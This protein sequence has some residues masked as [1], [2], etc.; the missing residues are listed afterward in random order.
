LRI[1][2]ATC[3]EDIRHGGCF[4]SLSCAPSLRPSRFFILRLQPLL[5]M[6]AP[7]FLHRRQRK[8][9]PLPLSDAAMQKG[10]HSLIFCSSPQ[11]QPA[12][13]IIQLQS[14]FPVFSLLCL[15]P[16]LLDVFLSLGG[17]HGTFPFLLSRWI[18]AESVLVHGRIWNTIYNMLLYIIIK[19]MHTYQLIKLNG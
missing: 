10:I 4:S 16:R 19:H 3:D 15:R 12:Y 6:D 9:A 1:G 7:K 13:P 18:G 5:V 14:N 2:V 8:A 17:I 11:T